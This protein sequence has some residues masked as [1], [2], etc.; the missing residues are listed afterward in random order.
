MF[1]VYTL[2]MNTIPGGFAIAAAA[3]HWRNDCSKNLSLWL[4]V[5][6]LIFNLFMIGLSWDGRVTLLLCMRQMQS[7]FAS[8]HAGGL[9]KRLLGCSVCLPDT[10]SIQPTR[11]SGAGAAP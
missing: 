9:T 4:V 11:L 1:L 10:P 2:A 8:H 6:A 3:V 7:P 5:M